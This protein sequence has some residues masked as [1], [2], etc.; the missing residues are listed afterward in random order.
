MHTI[1][2]RKTDESLMSLD[3][4]LKHDAWKDLLLTWKSRVSCLSAELIHLTS[5]IRLSPIFEKIRCDF[6]VNTDITDNTTG[7]SVIRLS[8]V[9]TTRVDGPS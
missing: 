3:D 8:P 7:P 9:S 2:L 5:D 1:P 4:D 6:S